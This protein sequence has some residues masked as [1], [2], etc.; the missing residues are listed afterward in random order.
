MSKLTESLRGSRSSLQRVFA[1]PGLRR[2]NIAY[3]VSNM[4]DWAY[5][6]V[7]S[8]FA[9]QHGGPT[10]LGVFG[11]VR[12][13]SMAIA[14]PFL[15][16]FGDRFPRK[17]VMVT[18]DIVRAV[19]V[20]GATVVVASNGPALA[21]YVLAVTSSVVSTAFRPAQAALLP[22]L[23][24]D[25]G[26]LTAA[27]AAASTIESLGFFGGPAI[28]ALLLAVANPPMVFALDAASFVW[29]ATFLTRIH[30]E[31]RPAPSEAKETSF[32]VEATR[33]F[34]T[35][36]S[37]RNLRLL[38][39][40]FFGQTVIA[41]ASLVFEVAI[42]LRLLH[43]GRPGVGLLEATIGVGG[44]VGGFLALGLAGRKRPSF[45]FGVGI[46][47]WSA[48]LLLLAA[49]PTIAAAVLMMALIGMGNSLVDV[50]G[51]TVLQRVAP[52][53]VL[54]RVFGAVESMLIAGMGLGALLMPLFI[55]T[56]GL[57]PG[58]AI[59]GL[60]VSAAGLAAF[61]GLNR[62]DTTMRPPARA[63]LVANNEILAP[64][65]EA[66]QEELARSLIEVDVPVGEAVVVEGDP[67][68]RFYL[69][70]QGSA[71]VSKGGVVVGR[72]GP[73]EAF[74]EIALLRDVPR[75]A[76]V[77]ALEDMKL[78]ALSARSSLT[79]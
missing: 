56:I 1:N 21:V 69:I 3:A 53:E 26:E 50:N 40:L 48:P 22:A 73:G 51:F 44:I 70:E 23:A 25:P 36:L 4:G 78:C 58:L 77:R 2:L 17:R 33:G 14:G 45:H 30:V 19:I 43:I 34:R 67:G 76:T 10:V 66:V 7:V 24:R 52:E 6:V 54:S 60:A 20:S 71:E 72:L 18:A 39:A 16:S 79:R 38:T 41:A 15:S 63:A 61:P 32:L 55:A 5:A 37:D 57:R 28:A 42:A 74:G 47:L 65:S 12:Y 35:V 62:I 27:N 29:S 49:W 46:I 11:V 9:F 8:I 75:Q 59:L 13:V 64:L 68:D 31:A